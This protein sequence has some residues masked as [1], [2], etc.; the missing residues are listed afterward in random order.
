MDESAEKAMT[1]R[2]LPHH[3]FLSAMIL[4]LDL[5]ILFYISNVLAP[6]VRAFAIALS[7]RFAW[8]AGWIPP[9]LWITVAAIVL[10]SAL[11]VKEFVVSNRTTS[12]LVNVA[13]LVLLVALGLI[14]QA[15]VLLLA[16]KTMMMPPVP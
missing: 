8:V 1:R 7:P 15:A 13:G 2:V 5:M 14:L 10:G 16:G 11:L 3:R 12:L 6:F 9:Q 4:I